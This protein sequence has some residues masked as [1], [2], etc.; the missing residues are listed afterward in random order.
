MRLVVVGVDRDG[1]VD[2]A[3]PRGR[4]TDLSWPLGRARFL[5]VGESPTPPGLPV[6]VERGPSAG[7]WRTPNLGCG[8]QPGRIVEGERGL[9]A[10]A[11]F[12]PTLGRGLDPEPIADERGPTVTRAGAPILGRWR[13]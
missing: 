7:G 9:P 1:L 5:E 11:G 2:M 3:K 6:E 8:K 12:A 10:R 13:R 4:E